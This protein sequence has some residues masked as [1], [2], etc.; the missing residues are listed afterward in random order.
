MINFKVNEVIYPIIVTYKQVKNINLKIN[1]QNK[2]TISCPNDVPFKKVTL[3]LEKHQDWLT[4]R[5]LDNEQK[6]QT[7]IYLNEET[8]VYLY[9]KRYQVIHTTI[10]EDHLKIVK[11]VI[12]LSSKQCFYRNFQE[13]L[14]AL[15]YQALEKLDV[16]ATMKVKRYKTRW[17]CCHHQTKEITLNEKLIALPMEIIDYVI[18]H[19]ISH[20]SVPNH[21]PSFY[22][23]LSKICPN[24]KALRKQIKI[25]RLNSSR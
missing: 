14:I 12:Y 6:R 18:C 1:E 21:S 5:I 13:Q 23:T 8:T 3:F 7:L 24:Y 15:G 19:E 9:G 17:G 20:L 4:K 25:Y 22:K 16:K 10:Q 2:I 11:D